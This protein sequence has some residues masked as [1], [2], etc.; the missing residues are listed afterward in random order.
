MDH[1]YRGAS[2]IRERKRTPEW[3]VFRNYHISRRLAVLLALALFA[4]A[5]AS[6]AANDAADE[7]DDGQ[8]SERAGAEIIRFAFAPDPVWDYLKD[9]GTLAQWESEHNVRVVDTSTWDEFTYF[10]GGHGDIISTATYELPLLERE[11]KTKTVTFGK[12]N[13][14]RNVPLTRS[15]SGY[16]TFADLPDG[17]KVA[18]S[19]AVGATVVWGMLIEKLHGRTLASGT[20]DF[21]L[22]VADNALLAE[23]VRSGEVEVCICDPETAARSLRTGELTVM[24]EGRTPQDLYREITGQDHFGLMSNMFTATEAWYEKNQDLAVA[25]AELWQ[26]GLNLWNSNLEEIVSI[27]PQHF[28]VESEED[29]QFVTDYLKEKDWFVDEVALTQE[30]IDGEIQMYELMK[31]TGFMEEAEQVPRFEVLNIGS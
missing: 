11:T 22:V 30:W 7:N 18:A 25:F 6:G 23:L 21:E 19:S 27:Y 9:T 24:Y 2:T 5:C 31:E 15:D 13:H 3:G 4:T 20:G 29:V 14:V 10:A 8:Q 26:Q 17:A 16:E 28:A 12:Y 1:G